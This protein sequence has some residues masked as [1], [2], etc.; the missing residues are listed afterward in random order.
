MIDKTPEYGG[1]DGLAPVRAGRETAACRYAAVAGPLQ[2]VEFHG[3]LNISQMCY[4]NVQE[5]LTNSEFLRHRDVSPRIQSSGSDTSTDFEARGGSNSL[6]LEGC[7]PGRGG[8]TAPACRRQVWNERPREVQDGLIQ[9]VCT[10]P[11]LNWHLCALIE[12]F[13]ST[14]KRA[15]SCKRLTSLDRIW[16]S[17]CFTCTGSTDRASRW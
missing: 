1:L 14:I 3:A 4:I 9:M 16:R 7:P 17:T 10:L 2:E 13:Q 15:M 11:C 6:P 5:T 12:G 8:R